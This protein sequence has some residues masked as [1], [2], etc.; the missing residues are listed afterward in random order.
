[1]RGVVNGNF[2][3]LKTGCHW[4]MLPKD[5]PHWR[6]VHDY[7]T[8][9]R[10]QGV[11][12]QLN[13]NLREQEQ[14]SE[15]RA[16]TP[17]AGSL[18]SQ[19]VKTTQKGGRGWDNSKQVKGRKRHLVVDTLGLVLKAFVTEAYYQDRTVASCPCCVSR[20]PAC[21]NCGPMVAIAGRG[22]RSCRRLAPSASR[23]SNMPTN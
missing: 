7:F 14:L 13:T 20:F 15:G 18:D 21:V 4:R 23:S 22:C 11:W 9:W 10:K 3:L 19:S 12:E 8:K 17:S 1:M 2:Y 5:F 16:V 6:T